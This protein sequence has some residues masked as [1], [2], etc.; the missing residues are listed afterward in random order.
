LIANWFAKKKKKRPKT[1][2]AFSIDLTIPGLIG[3]IY[4]NSLAV[5]QQEAKT[6]EVSANFFKPNLTIT[7]LAS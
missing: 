7:D 1:V 5:E 6:A 2:F 3:S 4:E